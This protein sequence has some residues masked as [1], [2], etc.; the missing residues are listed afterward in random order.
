MDDSFNYSYI[1]LIPKIPNVVKS[2][3]YRPISLCNV[4]YKLDSK[5]LANM[6]KIILPFIISPNQSAFIPRCLIS[7]NVILVYV[8]LHSMPRRQNGREG[9]MTLKLDM[10]KVYD[11]IE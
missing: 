2:S 5:F 3:D 6:L 11:R 8:A 1:V 7:D 4:I 10:L 9:S